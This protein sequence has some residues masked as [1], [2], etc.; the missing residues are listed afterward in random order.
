MKLIIGSAAAM[1]LTASLATAA[2]VSSED[3][4]K[5]ASSGGAA[6][7]AMGHL[8]AEK[9]TNADV[10]AFANKMVAEH[11]KVGRATAYRTTLTHGEAL[12]LIANVPVGYSSAVH[13]RTCNT[14]S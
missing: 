3:F 7:V 4:V 9:A 14:R 1:L 13:S 12:D 2:D 6:E 10:K 11:T 5:D 8:G